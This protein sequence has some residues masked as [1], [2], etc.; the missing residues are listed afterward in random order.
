MARDKTGKF[1][2]KAVAR[3]QEKLA[4]D[5]K[6]TH[7]EEL[8]D[9]TGASR[10]YDVVIRGTNAGHPYLGIIECRDS[11]KREGPRSISAFSK[12]MDNLGANLR[13]MVSRKG[14]TK[15]A[16]L[17]AK[18]EHVLCYSPLL[19]DPEGIGAAFGTTWFAKVYSWGSL[20]VTYFF[21]Q[22]NLE[23][24][25]FDPQQVLLDGKKV[26]DWFENELATTYD[27]TQEPKVTL[28]IK[29]QTPRPL[30]V[31]DKFHDASGVTVV[32]HRVVKNMKRWVP[33]TGDALFDWQKK[34]TIV[35]PKTG[36]IMWPFKNGM[37]GWKEFKGSIDRMLKKLTD[38][39]PK[40]FFTAHTSA[41]LPNPDAIDLTK[42]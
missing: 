19:E 26:M 12:E 23:I 21:T 9:R 35:P 2:E 6:V 37:E 20:E 28:E 29:F 3:I 31:G 30:Q 18:H 5:A 11:K 41:F 14:F 42:Y 8:T 33:L 27:T 7:D 24:P 39:H 16:L 4:P 34:K 22:P 38:D 15:Q 32:A 40:G 36:L 1:F 10:Q 13:I 25:G 17:V